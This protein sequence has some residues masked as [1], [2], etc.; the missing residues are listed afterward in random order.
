MQAIPID[1]D[2]WRISMAPDARIAAAISSGSWSP[3][4]DASG[5]AS[6]DRTPRR[7]SSGETRLTAAP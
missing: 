2:T 3:S 4:V 5:I 1:R 6:S 7:A